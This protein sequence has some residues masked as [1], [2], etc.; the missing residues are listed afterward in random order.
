[1][2]GVAVLRGYV[3]AKQRVFQHFKVQMLED[4]NSSDSNVLTGIVIKQ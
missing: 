4:L 2:Q 1:M 3:R